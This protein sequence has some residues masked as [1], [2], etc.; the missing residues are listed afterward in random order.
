MHHYLLTGAGFS[1]NW[2]GW[3]AN[4]AFE[5]L[6]GAPEI[7]DYLRNVLWEAKLRGEGFEGAL[8]VVQGGHTSNKS[9]ESKLRL[10]RLTQAVIGMFNTM[11]TAFDKL[12]YRES[13]LRLQRFLA[14][15]DAIFTLNQDL[16][17]ETIYAGSVRFSERWYC[18]HLPYMK[19]IKEPVQPYNF[20]LREPLTQNAEFITYEN[21]QPIYKLHGSCNWFAEPEGERLLVMGG[22]KTASIGAFHVLKQYY[23][24][25][26]TMLSQPDS[27]LMI[28]GY[29]FGD[30]H[31]NEAIRMGAAKG[32]RLFIVDPLGVDVIDKRSPQAQIPEP[33][34]DLMQALMPGIIGASRR[35]VNEII[36]SDQ[37][38]YQKVMRFF[39]AQA[40]IVRVSQ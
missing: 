8:S 2:G 20:M 32:L 26:Q 40:H 21:S 17:L 31:I 38:E 4:E 29:S 33:P 10:D 27:H 6:L 18:S 9:A 24:E 12:D 37:V 11:Q 14:Q 5:Y 15:F 25:F 3:L 19:F 36:N 22:N 16:L 13:N 30:P 7:D 34:R 23:A 35:S 28:I 1:R 39:E